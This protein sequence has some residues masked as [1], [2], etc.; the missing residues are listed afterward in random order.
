MKIIIKNYIHN[1]NIGKHLLKK[2]TVI[3]MKKK[4]DK[5]AQICIKSIKLVRVRFRKNLY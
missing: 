5:I 4:T 2:L 1:R 3:F